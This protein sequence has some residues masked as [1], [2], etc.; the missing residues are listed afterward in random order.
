MAEAYVLKEGLMLAQH[1]V[2]NL[3]IIQSYCMEVVQRM[4]DGGFSANSAGALYDE[5]N[6]IWSGF[7]D[8]IIE[9]YSME[10][11]QSAHNLTRRAI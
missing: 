10:I 3:L 5:C 11:N 1:I 6:I 9:H 8:I 2:R 4:K 7:H